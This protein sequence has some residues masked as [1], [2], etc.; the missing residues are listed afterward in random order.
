MVL[1]PWILFGHSVCGCPPS[2]LAENLRRESLV[3][4]QSWCMPIIPDTKNWTWVIERPCAECGFDAGDYD[5]REIASAILA[6]AATW[7]A[8]LGRDDV[9]E[10]PNDHTWSPLE[11]GAH[12]RDVL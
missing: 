1:S 9:R 10:R 2:S 6:T 8:V 7:R 12:V 3:V 4:R 11:Y 5:D